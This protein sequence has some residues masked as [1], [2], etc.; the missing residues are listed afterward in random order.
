MASASF[1]H[2]G[3]CQVRV[4]QQQEMKEWGYCWMEGLLQHGDRVV[5]L[6]KQSVQGL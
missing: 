1:T 2:E 3:P 5:R 4:K 6:G